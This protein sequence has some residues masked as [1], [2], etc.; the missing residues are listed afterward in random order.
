M[1][2]SLFAIYTQVNSVVEPPTHL[3]VDC[4]VDFRIGYI[5]QRNIEAR[6]GANDGAGKPKL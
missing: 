3:R 2:E 6:I 1:Y 5:Y 4:A